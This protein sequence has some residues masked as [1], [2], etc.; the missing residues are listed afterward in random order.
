MSTISIFSV[1]VD[2]KYLIFLFSILYFQNLQLTYN[3]GICLYSQQNK[4]SNHNISQNPN[5]IINKAFRSGFQTEQ[6]SYIFLRTLTVHFLLH[7]YFTGA[8][9]I[10]SG[11]LSHCNNSYLVSVAK[12]LD[13]YIFIAPK[14]YCI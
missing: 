9:L 13:R 4:L 5:K 12:M 10:S 7:Q 8:C 2:R 3:D 14:I 1:C 11:T 6:I